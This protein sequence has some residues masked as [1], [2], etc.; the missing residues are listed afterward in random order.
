MGR[1]SREQRL[2]ESKRGHTPVEAKE[3]KNDEEVNTYLLTTLGKEGNPITNSDLYSRTA[4]V[5]SA[6]TGHQVSN[7]GAAKFSMPNQ[8]Y[9][10]R[11]N[12]KLK[13]QFLAKRDH[14]VA[15]GSGIGNEGTGAND[16]EENNGG[17]VGG[18]S[19]IA[20]GGIGKGNAFDDW[21]VGGKRPKRIGIGDVQSSIFAGCTIYI[22]GYTGPRTSDLELKRLI[23]MHG[24]NVSYHCTSACTHILVATGLSG[25]KSQ[26][27][28]DASSSTRKGKRKVVHIDW[29]LDSVVQ[30]KKLSETG[31]NVIANKAQPTLFSS[32]D[33]GPLPPSGVVDD[34]IAKGI[35]DRHAGVRHREIVIVD[36]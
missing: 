22:N 3:F 14:V 1:L 11:R 5:I 19:E 13:E 28:L 15:S 9:M 30:G 25:T 35:R 27:F 24:G 18:G 32:L 4:H 33:K 8:T 2:K 31:Y 7:R 6:S 29:A 12:E 34:P 26:K 23:A 17:S 16:S 20:A 21:I 10:Q 36:D